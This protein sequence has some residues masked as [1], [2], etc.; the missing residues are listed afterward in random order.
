MIELFQNDLWRARYLLKHSP[1]FRAIEIDYRETL[2]NPRE[3]ARRIAT[4]LGRKLPID[5]MA[6]IV[7]PNLY[8][9]R[10]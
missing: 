5:R 4:F 9:N 2:E 6:E 8:R 3:Q 7:D 1:Q 10:R